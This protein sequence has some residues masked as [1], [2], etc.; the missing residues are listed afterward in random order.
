MTNVKDNN[1]QGSQKLRNR[2]GKLNN[3]KYGRGYQHGP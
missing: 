1:E 2:V 3:N